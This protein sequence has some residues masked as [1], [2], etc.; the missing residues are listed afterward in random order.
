[1][2]FGPLSLFSIVVADLTNGV[3]AELTAAVAEL[4]AVVAELGVAESTCRRLD[5]I[6]VAEW[7][8]ASTGR[9]MVRVPLR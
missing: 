9:S 6:P 7:V 8:R 2:Y 4:T 1:M 3:V 5:R